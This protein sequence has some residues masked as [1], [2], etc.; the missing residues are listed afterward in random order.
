M[1]NRIFALT[2]VVVFGAVAAFAQ[3]PTPVGGELFVGSYPGYPRQIGADVDG[4]GNFVVAWYKS[5]LD[6]GVKA[7]QFTSAGVGGAEIAINS[8]PASSNVVDVSAAESGNFAVVWSGND[9]ASNPATNVRVFNSGGSSIVGPLALGYLNPSDAAVAMN[10]TTGDFVVAWVD[11]MGGGV[12]KFDSAGTPVGPQGSFGFMP[13]KVEVAMDSTGNFVVAWDNF[14]GVYGSSFDSAGASVDPQFTVSASGYGQPSVA[15]VGAG[16]FVVAWVDS[17]F[18]GQDEIKARLFAADGT[19]LSGE[20]PVDEQPPGSFGGPSVTGNAASFVVAWDSFGG[21]ACKVLPSPEQ[22]GSGTAIVARLFDSGG[23]PLSSEFIV[24]TYTTGYQRSPAV[25]MNSAGQFIVGWANGGSYPNDV[26]VQA[27]AAAPPEITVSDVAVLEGDAGTVNAV[28]T[29][30]LTPA[31]AG[32]V[33]VDYATAN[34]TAT[35]GSDYTA[36]SS[37]TLTFLAGETSKQVMVSVTGDTTTETNETF[38]LNLSN[39]T[40]ATILDPQGLGTITDDDA[41][42]CGTGAATNLSPSGG[43]VASPV[44][45][46][47]TGVSS[48]SFYEVYVGVNGGPLTLLGLTRDTTLTK[49]VSPGAIEW[50]V[51]TEFGTG[52]RSS[53]SAIASVTVTGPPPPPPPPPPAC[54]ISEKPL[55]SV[56]AESTTGESYKLSWT[57]VTGA[58]TYQV[59]ESLNASFADASTF[60]VTGL[61]INFK[62]PGIETAT[63]YHYRI[64]AVADCDSTKFGP[65]STIIRV[66]TLPKPMPSSTNP[67]VVTEFGNQELVSTQLF[68]PGFGA[69]AKRGP[70]AASFTVSSNEL[71]LTPNPVQGE[72]PPGGATVELVAD[73]T[74]LELGA[75]MATITVTRNDGLGRTTMGSSTSSVPVS[76]SLVAPITPLGKVTGPPANTLF[77][78]AVANVGGIDSRWLSD[79]RISN[80]ANTSIQ[81]QLTFT[82]T[83]KDGTVEGKKTG[84]TIRPGQTVAMDDIVRQWFGFGDLADG[85]NG[86]LEI[87]PLNFQGKGADPEAA[88]AA[89]VATSRTYTRDANSLASFGQLM[90]SVPFSSFIGSTLPGAR[91]SMQ[92]VSQNQFARTNIGL[93]EGAGKPVNVMLTVFDRL[94]TQLGQFPVALLAGEHRQL[95][96]LLALNNISVVDGRVEATV[97]G[98]DGSITAYASVV[99]SGTGDPTLVRGIDPRT[100]SASKYVLAGVADLSNGGANWRSDVRIFNGSGVAQ[101]ADLYFYPQGSTTPVGPFAVTIGP[102]EVKVLEGV[103]KTQFGLENT[104]GAMHVVTP[105]NSSLVITGETFDVNEDGK[106]GQTIPSVTLAEA[107]GT[108]DR[109]LQVLQLEDSA[110]YRTNLGLAELTGKPATVRVQLI[111]PLSLSAPGMTVELGANEF[112]QLNGVIRTL[113]GRDVYNARISVKVTGGEGRILAYG[114]VVDNETLDATYVPGQ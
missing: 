15:P 53:R 74:K 41:V 94:G 93:V 12:Q 67:Q 66:V 26:R 56:V 101:L 77:I 87:R 54:G 58:S 89:T 103:V 105:N 75:N 34:G 2:A 27:F 7:R 72:L 55:P 45:F 52:C 9:P 83:E 51:V 99:S 44:T 30:T 5:N 4:S 109:A 10:R 81:Y 106:Y 107:V 102:N 29:V 36:L 70:L 80:A 47:W 37:T 1:R 111:I 46:S 16:N 35:A 92:Q 113:A 25:G 110:Q 88:L 23:S 97:T 69:S 43:E 50:Q 11:S 96:Q 90:P 49:P 76:V 91:L 22:D 21:Y 100:I 59:Q 33:T 28:F 31:S 65:Y 32:T 19:A 95:N 24:N 17:P 108:T 98:G 82:A 38:F 18:C 42:V 64:R 68:I 86:T 79:V 84:Y 6:T 13:S 60:S 20:I 57:A 85:T 62:H 71:W 61:S 73:P 39:P 40:N 3:A 112:K 48:A 114:S 78:P 104:G 14:Y 63:P 8:Y